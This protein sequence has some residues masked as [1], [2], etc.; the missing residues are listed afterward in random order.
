MERG[1]CVVIVGVVASGKTTIIQRL[2]E[3]MPGT[4][5]M[6]TYTTRAPR[7]GEIKGGDRIFVSQDEFQDMVRS[8]EIFE[9]NEFAGSMY[10]S[11]KS[12]LDRLLAEHRVVFVNVNVDGALLYQQYVPDAVT[13]FVDAPNEHIVRRI[14][15]RGR[16]DEEEME[17]RLKEADRERSLKDRFDER[18]EN[19]DG[20][21]EMS[22]ARIR[23]IAEERLTR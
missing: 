15:L 8:G 12:V 16:M 11:S 20:N 9:H 13:I 7:D 17:W 21:L 10:G 2:I 4:A 19:P 14:K 18:I 23:E 1:I 5:M 6:R 3:T 22:V